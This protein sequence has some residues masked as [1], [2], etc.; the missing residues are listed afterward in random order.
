MQTIKA[1]E[2]SPGMLIFHNH[3]WLRVFMVRRSASEVAVHA[4][5][6]WAAP[7]QGG[8]VYFF[9]PDAALSTDR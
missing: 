5:G 4:R 3:V 6:W 1:D 9:A 7:R 8:S 2:V